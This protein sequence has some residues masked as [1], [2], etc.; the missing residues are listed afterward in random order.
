MESI[1]AS[2]NRVILIGNLVRDIEIRHTTNAKLAVCQNAIAVNDR[3][4]NA[5]GEWVDETSFV[6]LTF[7]GRTAELVGQYLTKGSPV[8]VEGKLKQDTWEKD[9]QKRSKL[10]VIV[11]RMQFLTG[12]SE[13]SKGDSGQKA[14]TS[15][16][17]SDPNGYSG[18]PDSVQHP[19]IHEEPVYNDGEM[20]F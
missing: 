13:G 9:G 17:F 3:R 1:M 20:P 6:D 7:F 4:K 12:K 16:R 10:Y 11:E 14:A 19:E 2:F 15:S 5:A 8:F 18:A